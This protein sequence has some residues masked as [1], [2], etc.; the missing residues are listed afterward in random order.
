[1][2]RFFGIL[3]FAIIVNSCKEKN[4][5]RYD[6]SDSR[7]LNSFLTSIESRDIGAPVMMELFENYLLLV[8]PKLNQFVSVFDLRN[9]KLINQFVHKGQ[10]EN[11]LLSVSS[12]QIQDSS[13]ILY[14]RILKAIYSANILE[15]ISQNR[16][17]ILKK[18]KLTY[19][20][21]IIA[22]F[23][24][25]KI[26]NDKYITMGI[27]NESQFA[28][29]S[30]NPEKA[31]SFFENYP[32]DPDVS[33][34]NY[35]INAFAYQGKITIT[36]DKK[37][38]VWASLFGHNLKFFQ[39]KDDV[40]EKIKEYNYAYPKYRINNSNDTYDGVIFSRDK[41]NMILDIK[42]TSKF[43]YL[44]VYENRENN[45][46]ELK[47]NIIYIYD[48]FGN[49]VCRLILDK[50]VSMITVDATDDFI[51]CFTTDSENSEPRII[52]YDLKKKSDRNEIFKENV[53]W[54][55]QMNLHTVNDNI[56]FLGD[57][58]SNS[59]RLLIVNGKFYLMDSKSELNEMPDFKNPGK[60]SISEVFNKELKDSLLNKI[61]KWRRRVETVII[62]NTNLN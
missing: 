47:S 25:S 18:T 10:G 17:I 28:L 56:Y 27:I 39:N 60:Y 3:F 13:L 37:N 31:V 55:E 41:M 23:N 30:T 46:Y 5:I 21:L 52:Y 32:N 48:L 36:P 44:L 14:D 19:D 2:V 40:M 22:P 61:P 9:G 26:E 34:S 6:F 1:M 43:C 50:Y 59:L 54:N 11:E 51:F 4:N 62:V 53:R 20:K 15:C 33:K 49:A 45:D 42:T 7:E 8:E 38:L 57:S 29:L 16:E 24:V 58:S 35:V 12:I